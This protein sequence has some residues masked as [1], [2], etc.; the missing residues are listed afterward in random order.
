MQNLSKIF[1]FGLLCL[2]LTTAAQG[3]DLDAF[4]GQKGIL[5]IAGGTAHIP[6]MKE[7]AELIMTS[8][9]DIR[10]TIAGGGT[11]V[12][13]KQVGEGLVEIGNAGRKATDEEIATYKLSMVKW[14]ID[15]VGAVVNPQNKVTALTATQLQDIFSGKIVNWKEVGGEDRGINI[16]DR[17]AA[18]G[19]RE[20]F[21]KK[22]LQ[23]GDVTKKANV[24]VSNGA[25]KTAIAQ[26]PYGIGYV[27][28]GHIDGTVTP[29]ALDGVVPN[30]ENVKSGAYGVA[31]GLFSL[32]KGKPAGLAKSF[33]DFLLSPT[34]QQIARDKGF[35]AVK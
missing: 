6:V 35:V 10:I 1:I 27:S 32:T 4:V 22:A 33:L 17:D 18:S 25:M 28:V 5:K 15:G 14:A 3:S 9:P 12:G 20:V 24:V 31:R 19:T 26:D 29:V 11:G 21:W 8:N 13:I 2:L 7:A 23:S 34:G 16:Y 30:L